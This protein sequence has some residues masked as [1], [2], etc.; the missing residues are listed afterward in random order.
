MINFDGGITYL[1]AEGDG[2]DS[3]GS[4]SLTGGYVQQ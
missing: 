2:I 1:N 4:V 3:N